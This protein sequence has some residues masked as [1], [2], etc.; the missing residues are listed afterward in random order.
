MKKTMETINEI[1]QGKLQ[2]LVSYLSQI[3]DGFESIAEDI[4]NTNLKTAMIALSVESKQYAEEISDQLQQFN[5]AIPLISTDQLWQRIETDTHEQAAFSKGGEIIA[6]CNNC[7]MYFNKLYEDV[8]QE[9][10]PLT[11]FKDIITYQLYA[12]QCA[13]MK[14]RLLNTLRFSNKNPV[15]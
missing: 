12:T 10:F 14:I 8:L 9:Y 13:F 3:T 11:Y 15:A 7:E 5:I 4:E 6:L 2:K 1:L